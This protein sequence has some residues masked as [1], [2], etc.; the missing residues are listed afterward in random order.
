MPRSTIKRVAI[1]TGTRAEYGLLRTV[2]HAVSRHPKLELQTIVTGMHLLP[3]FGKTS[4]HIESDGWRIDAKVKMQSGK[5]D[6]LDQAEGFGSGVRGI[7]RALDKLKSD[8][9]L[10]LGDRIEAMAGA[11]A[12]LLLD[13]CVGHIHGGDVAPGVIDDSLRHAITKLAHLHFP[14]TLDAAKRIQRLGEDPWRIHTVGA[15]G[16]DEILDVQPASQSELSKILGPAAKSDYALI[17]QHPVGMSAAEERKAMTATIQAVHRSGLIGVIIHP[18]S[19][20]GHQGILRA[21]LEAKRKYGWPSFSS[22]A[23]N[24]YLQVMMNARVLVGNS[25]SGII[26]SAVAGT[27]A[28]DIG[29]RQEGRLVCGPSVAHCGYAQRSIRAAIRRAMRKRPKRGQKS[30]YGNGHA[31]PRIAEILADTPVNHTLI[32]KRIAY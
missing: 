18:C 22:L 12:G 1:L 4:R 20:P 6:R 14:A 8:V 29:P 31:G 9:V 32:R 15:P 3:N 27:P 24:D 2:M 21:I 5:D 30:V 10:V 17:I 16:L 19:D 25:S 28:V 13:R 23:R 26:E 11:T 7:A